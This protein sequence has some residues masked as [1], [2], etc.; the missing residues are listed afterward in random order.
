MSI[1]RGWGRMLEMY[2][3]MIASVTLG[4]T[5]VHRA[6]APDLTVPPALNLDVDA[7][8]LHDQQVA[9]TGPSDSPSSSAVAKYS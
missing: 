7:K 3:V 9:K 6:M 1:H 8:Q 2:A 5:I 4:T